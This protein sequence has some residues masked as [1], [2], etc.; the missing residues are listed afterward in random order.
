MKKDK[1]PITS[2]FFIIQASE[3]IAT[4]E[5]KQDGIAQKDMQETTLN[6]K[7]A[8]QRCHTLYILKRS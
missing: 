2:L 6:K 5:G 1:K 4:H 3:N 8:R 7:R